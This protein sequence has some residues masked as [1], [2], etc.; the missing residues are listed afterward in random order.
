MEV[1]PLDMSSNASVIAFADH[2][3]KE[4]PRLDAVIANA[5]VNNNSKFNLVEGNEETINT[6]VITPALLACLLIPK[7][8]EK[9]LKSNTETYFTLVGC[10]LDLYENA[11]FDVRNAPDGEVFAKL[12]DEARSKGT[13]KDRYATSRL[14]IL[15]LIKALASI[16]P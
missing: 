4:L 6:A 3:K 1:W 16:N 5:G 2:V 15:F 9:G 14:L 7:L 13:M 11:E 12:N 10:E 8:R